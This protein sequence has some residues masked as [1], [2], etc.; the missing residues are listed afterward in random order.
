MGK[1]A[2]TFVGQALFLA[3]REFLPQGAVSDSV[4]NIYLEPDGGS[5]ISVSS[6][7]SEE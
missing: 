1:C 3:V 2:N 6:Q 7:S 4:K 5:H